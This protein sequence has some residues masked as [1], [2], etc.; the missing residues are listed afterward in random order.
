MNLEKQAERINKAHKLILEEKTGT[1]EKF[2]EKLNIS[3][4]QLYN[5]IDKLKEY[6]APIKY[7]K[8]TKNFY[9]SNTFDLELKYSFKIIFDKN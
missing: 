2:A 4:S 9:Y 6:D 8:K 3:R 5:L 7:S 1:P